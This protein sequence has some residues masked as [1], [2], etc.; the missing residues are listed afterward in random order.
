MSYLP[1]NKH[2]FHQ[3][4]EVG[5]TTSTPYAEQLFAKRPNLEF[6]IGKFRTLGFSF[7]HCF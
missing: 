6:L 4:A 1:Q 2:F 3:Q 5:Q 7:K